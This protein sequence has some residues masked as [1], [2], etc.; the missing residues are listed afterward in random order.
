MI[1]K[2]LFFLFFSCLL[3]A[4]NNYE[5]TIDSCLKKFD[6][7][8][9]SCKSSCSID[10]SVNQNCTKLCQEKRDRCLDKVFLKD[11]GKND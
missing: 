7:C 2:L 8:E 10:D 5:Y 11:K 9:E 1:N 3:F 4:G 6:L